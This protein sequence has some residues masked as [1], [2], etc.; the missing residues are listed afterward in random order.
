MKIGAFDKFSLIDYSGYA[1]AIIFTQGCNFRCPFCHN[2][3]LV[4]PEQFETPLPF[5][6][7][8]AF[9][10]KRKGLLDAVE[11]TGG[12][13]TLQPDLLEKM[14][15]L[16]ALGYRIKLDTNGTNPDVVK[17]AILENLVDYIAM[18]VKGSLERYSEI[19]G[20]NVDT[21]KIEQSIN[22]IKNSAPDYEFRTT[23]IR[24]FHDAAEMER[25]GAL[26][27]GAKRYFI[28]NA[29]FDK[30]VKPNFKRHPL[31]RETLEEFCKIIKSHNVRCEIRG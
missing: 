25:I 6:E 2:P 19:A 11:F 8:Y 20:V 9:L 7:I 13:P 24:G 1:T 15:A 5:E 22:L 17:Q 26:I 28:Q 23:L 14:Q 21:E 30:T 4:L 18:D 10:K 12:E 27:S 29:H 3:E 31:T 16:K